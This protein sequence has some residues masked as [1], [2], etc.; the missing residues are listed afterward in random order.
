MPFLVNF[1][2]LFVLKKSKNFFICFQ[3]ET[4]DKVLAKVND[5]A[6]KDEL[7]SLKKILQNFEAKLHEVTLKD[8][9]V[10]IYI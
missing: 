10:Y 4:I 8:Y 7:L 5:K 6:E 9:Q 2:R 3:R 1:A